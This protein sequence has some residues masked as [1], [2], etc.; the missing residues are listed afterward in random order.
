MDVMRI[1]LTV[2]ATTKHHVPIGIEVQISSCVNLKIAL[3]HETTVHGIIRNKLANR[4]LHHV[5]GCKKRAKGQLEPLS[6]LS[7][8]WPAHTGLPRRHGQEQSR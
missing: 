5:L 7:Q 3:Y 6:E 8:Q 4:R 2:V 1:V